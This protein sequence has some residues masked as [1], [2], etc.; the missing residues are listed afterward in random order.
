MS[1]KRETLEISLS[2]SVFFLEKVNEAI[3]QR[4]I[5]TYP[6]VN[7]YLAKLLEKYIVAD[8]LFD[9]KNDGAKR[10]QGTLAELYLKASGADGAQKIEMLKKLGE[11][12]LYISGYFGDS[13]QRKL[14]DVDYYVNMGGTAYAALSGYVTE[15]PTSRVFKEISEKFVMFVDVLG[16]ISGKVNDGSN[17]SILR[18]YEKYLR[19]GSELARDQILEKGLSLPDPTY[20]FPK[21]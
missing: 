15:N 6:A 3:S 2:P 17:R 8:N 20:K 1:E 9:E 21:Q 19:T 10:S 7:N 18:L 13:L 12:S 5:N 11:T 14:V 16:Y 4:N